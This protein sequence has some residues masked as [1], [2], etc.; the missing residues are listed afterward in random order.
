MTSNKHEVNFKRLLQKC[1]DLVSM[2]LH[3][4]LLRDKQFEKFLA[5]LEQRL[6]DLQQNKENNI[7]SETLA[8]YSRRL[9]VLLD[10]KKPKKP[11][12]IEIENELL[13][14]GPHNN[15]NDATRNEVLKDKDSTSNGKFEETVVRKRKQF[16]T[17]KNDKSDNLPQEF[18]EEVIMRN[19][20]QQDEITE[21]MTLLARTLKENSHGVAAILAKDNKNL[22]T[23]DEAVTSNVSV[24]TTTNDKLKT[25]TKSTFSW[26]LSY[27]MM[28]LCVAMIFMGTYMFIKLFPK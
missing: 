25:H 7:P 24:I 23:L 9:N 13:E 14:N 21:D 20:R 22:D 5:T 10:V 2:Q 18:F 11:S 4:T 19:R 27:W 26:T 12:P 17:D 15:H 16:F 3:E 1:E 6:L 8:T 28:M